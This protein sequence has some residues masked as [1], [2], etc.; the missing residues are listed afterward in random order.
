M[1]RE[2]ATRPLTQDLLSHEVR[3][4][5]DPQPRLPSRCT[6]PTPPQVGARPGPGGTL[7]SAPLPAAQRR[8][9]PRAPTPRHPCLPPLGLLYPG[10]GGPEDLRV[11][12]EEGQRPG[13]DGS[14]EPGTGGHGVRQARRRT[15]R[16]GEGMGSDHPG[17]DLAGVRGSVLSILG[18][19]CMPGGQ[20]PGNLAA[21][22]GWELP[23]PSRFR[24]KRENWRLY[25]LQERIGS[26]GG[27]VGASRS[28]G[29]LLGLKSELAWGQR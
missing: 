12:G 10:P 1:V 20:P 2:V 3:G 28:L 7:V 22:S 4:P 27:W 8:P 11:E 16:D 15:D 17:P 9:R 5:G 14:H 24:G 26:T 13:E 29:S 18:V 6:L 19:L 21:S 23:P 25:F